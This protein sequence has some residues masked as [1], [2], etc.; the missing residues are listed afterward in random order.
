MHAIVERDAEVLSYIQGMGKVGEWVPL[1]WKKRVMADD[2]GVSRS[3][4]YMHIDSLVE[5]G[6]IE[7]RHD[8]FRVLRRL[9]SSD[10]VQINSKS[11]RPL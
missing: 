8:A 4:L 10:V 9:E 2:L 7:Q 6:F 3:Q 5:K 11:R 1:C